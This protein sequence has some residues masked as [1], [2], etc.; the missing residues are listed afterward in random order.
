MFVSTFTTKRKFPTTVRTSTSLYYILL[1]FTC[2]AFPHEMS[3]CR[4]FRAFDGGL[5]I[6]DVP[7][8]LGIEHK[9]LTACFAL[10]FGNS[11]VAELVGVVVP[12]ISVLVWTVKALIVLAIVLL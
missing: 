7:P 11:A 4:R 1:R 12:L 8:F 5:A 3:E 6:L 2:K 10:I 9:L